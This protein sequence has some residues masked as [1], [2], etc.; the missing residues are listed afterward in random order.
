M[1]P[2]AFAVIPEIPLTVS[3]KLD[4]RALPAPTPIAARSYRQPAT[5]TECRMC[6]IFGRLFG[7]EQVSA[8]DSFFELGGHSLL[9]ARL[10]AQIRAEFGAELTVRTVFDT[11]TPAGLAARLV[12]QFRAEFDIIDALDEIDAEETPAGV[13]SPRTRR[14]GGSPGT[15]P[16]VLFA[17]FP[18]VKVSD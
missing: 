3:G 13:E 10:V 6:S 16:V 15:A 11:P 7:C 1:V 9:A 4:K 18:V 5:A 14:S 2:N 12:A 8:T 17:A